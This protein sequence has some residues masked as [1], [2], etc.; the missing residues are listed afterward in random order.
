MGYTFSKGGGEGSGVIYERNYVPGI[1]GY[2]F[3]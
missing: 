1:V 2:A 3:G